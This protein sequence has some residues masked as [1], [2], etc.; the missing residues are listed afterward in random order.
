M[1]VIAAENEMLRD[2][3]AGVSGR[4]REGGRRKHAALFL[5]PKTK[6]VRP[7]R[8][9]LR[10]AQTRVLVVSGS[11][12]EAPPMAAR[13]EAFGAEITRAE[14]LPAGLAALNAGSQPDLVIVDCA[15]GVAAADELSSALRLF[16]GAT[17][18]P[19]SRLLLRARRSGGASLRISVKCSFEKPVPA[20]L[21]SER[22]DGEFPE[23]PEP[24][25]PLPSVV[26]HLADAPDHDIGLPSAS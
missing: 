12:S 6:A 16:P 3:A 14:G 9:C 20:P 26:E 15:L 2:E 17:Q 10:A 1:A 8:N 22:S 25:V 13:L 4:L 18:E 23:A 19:A 5:S 21:L 7:P 11:P 24:G